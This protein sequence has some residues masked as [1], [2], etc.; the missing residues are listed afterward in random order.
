MENINGSLTPAT[1][2]II[3]PHPGDIFDAV[4]RIW[5]FHEGNIDQFRELEGKSWLNYFHVVKVDKVAPSKQNR[6]V[7][8]IEVTLVL[9]H[10]LGDAPFYIWSLNE[11]NIPVKFN[12]IKRVEA[13]E[14]GDQ[15]GKKQFKL[16][17]Q[18]GSLEVGKGRILEYSVVTVVLLLLGFLIWKLSGKIKI[19]LEKNRAD[20]AKRDEWSTFFY[21]VRSRED[22]EYIYKLKE[23]WLP[24][25]GERS[26]DVDKFLMNLDL[27]LI[28]I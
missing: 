27:S 14:K 10:S 28:H 23:E 13:K 20:R 22:F 11:L 3:S 16:L 5:P 18:P 6:E 17:E 8:E 15:N 25:L 26:G 9:K 4:I 2:Q 12:S 19:K 7:L 21:K 1:E 24:L